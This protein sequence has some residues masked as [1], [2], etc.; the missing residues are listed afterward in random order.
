MSA[1]TV[2]SRFQSQ[3]P[4][5]KPPAAK[6]VALGCV[7]DCF[8]HDTGTNIFPTFSIFLIF[9]MVVT[10]VW[11]L[12]TVWQRHDSPYSW[13]HEWSYSYLCQPSKKMFSLQHTEM[14]LIRGDSIVG[15]RNADWKISRYLLYI[16]V[17]PGLH[18]WLYHWDE[19][20]YCPPHFIK[21]L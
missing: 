16:C 12:F 4:H 2:S 18:H 11:Y 14:K 19:T 5:H 13:R 20:K 1:D 10:Q 15:I 21:L 6:L 3:L 7:T 8:S 9:P 17:Y